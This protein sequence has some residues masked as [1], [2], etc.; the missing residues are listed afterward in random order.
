M[1]HP[2]D[3]GHSI[4]VTFGNYPLMTYFS[5]SFKVPMYKFGKMDTSELNDRLFDEKEAFYD[6]SKRNDLAEQ[7]AKER[8]EKKAAQAEGKGATN[9]VAEGSGTA[10]GGVNASERTE[11]K[12]EA[13]EQEYAEY[14]QEAKENVEAA[15]AQQESAE[16]DAK[17]VQDIMKMWNIYKQ[18][19]PDARPEDIFGVSVEPKGGNL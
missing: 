11:T 1:N 2:G 19:H 8:Q 15:T 9:D 7:D 18:S 12:K 6:I 5:P 17:E 3:I 10:S 16:A 13:A 4:V 14:V